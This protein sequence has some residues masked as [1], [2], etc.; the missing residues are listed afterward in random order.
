MTATWKQ[1]K[2]IEWSTLSH[3]FQTFLEAPVTT[4]QRLYFIL[5]RFS[6]FGSLHCS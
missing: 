3:K 1:E 4:A 2:S 5:L 6:R